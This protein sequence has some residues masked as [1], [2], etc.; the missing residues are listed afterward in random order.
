MNKRQYKKARKKINRICFLDEFFLIDYTPEEYEHFL[1]DVD[2]YC[3]KHHRFMH[4]YDRLTSP[5][6]DTK[7]HPPLSK[8]RINMFKNMEKF[9]R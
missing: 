6:F 2:N 8:V 9:F 7:Y 4:Y 5:I 1:E 3:F